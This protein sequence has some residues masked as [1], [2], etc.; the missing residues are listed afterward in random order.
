MNKRD[1]ENLKQKVIEALLSNGFTPTPGGWRDYHGEGSKGII[2]VSVRAE[3]SNWKK[4]GYKVS[5]FG[6]FEDIPRAKAAG[7][8]CNPYSGKHNFLFI[9]SNS[10]DYIIEQYI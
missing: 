9:E 3:I 2:D 8:D 6:V 1:A 4:R 5:V 7:I 10:V